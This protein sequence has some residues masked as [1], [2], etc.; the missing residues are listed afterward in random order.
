MKIEKKEKIYHDVKFFYY[1]DCK[2]YI[3][4]GIH[5]GNNQHIGY[6]YQNKWKGL[7]LRNYKI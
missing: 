1:R 4:H 3:S 2:T 5:N 7:W 6:N